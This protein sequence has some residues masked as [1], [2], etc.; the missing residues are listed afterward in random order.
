MQKNQRGRVS[1]NRI[2]SVETRRYFIYILIHTYKKTTYS[3]V[4]EVFEHVSL[5][6]EVFEHVSIVFEVF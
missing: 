5:V 3:A 2:V 1:E 4:F 6:F